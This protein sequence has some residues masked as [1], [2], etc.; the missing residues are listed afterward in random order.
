MDA[1][2][3]ASTPL[4]MASLALCALV[5]AYS[6]AILLKSLFSSLANAAASTGLSPEELTAIEYA[7][8]F[9][10]QLEKLLARTVSIE[11][12][13]IEAP[14]PFQEQAW[15]RLLTICDEL[16]LVRSELNGLLEMREHRNATALAK[17]IS[18]ASN[19]IPQIPRP[20]NA[21]ELRKLIYWPRESRDLTL[22]IIAKL[23]DYTLNYGS[24][25]RQSYSKHF[26]EVISAVKNEL[27]ES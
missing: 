4:F 3:L 17:F 20:A 14:A 16:E 19:S 13:A 5:A 21:I 24:S 11:Q 9:H 2:L 27:S 25:K 22:R 12:L 18:G 8:I 7:G 1:Q 26:F 6:V 15:S 10:A 23:E